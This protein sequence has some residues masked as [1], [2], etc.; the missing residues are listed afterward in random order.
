[1]QNRVPFPPRE[2]Y[3]SDHP[4]TVFQYPSNG[5]RQGGCFRVSHA[6]S[7][8]HCPGREGSRHSTT[9]CLCRIPY[10]VIH[11]VFAYAVRITVGQQ[12][13]AEEAPD[14]SCGSAYGTGAGVAS[15]FI[16]TCNNSNN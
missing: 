13:L 3:P 2:Q 12:D 7:F 5:S 6:Y 15:Y 10:L 11:I 16:V 4:S 14:M 9:E 1:M 8:E